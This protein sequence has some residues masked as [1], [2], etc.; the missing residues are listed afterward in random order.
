MRGDSER[1]G[2][3]AEIGFLRP[4]PLQAGKLC[5]GL[6]SLNVGHPVGLGRWHDATPTQ[7]QPKADRAPR[8]N[9]GQAAGL[10]TAEMMLEKT[11]RPWARRPESDNA[12]PELS[13]SRPVLGPDAHSLPSISSERAGVL[14]SVRAG[15]VAQA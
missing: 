4:C 3:T 11:M 12:A 5:C 14:G 6:T 10:S 9:F 2:N 13:R 15:K 8:Q 1:F 7:G